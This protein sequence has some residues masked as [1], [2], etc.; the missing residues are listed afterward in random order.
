MKSVE[1]GP[2]SGKDMSP[3]IPPQ[4]LCP[5]TTIFSTLRCKTAYSMAAPTPAYF[6][7]SKGGTMLAMLRTM[8]A[9]PGWKSRTCDGQTRESEQA[10]TMNLGL[11]PLASSPYSCGFFSYFS[12]LKW[13]NPSFI[14]STAGLEGGALAPPF[15]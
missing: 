8:N 12:L 13:I 4:A 3:L 14:L 9:S 6:T 11:W 5:M 7:L 2:A 10:N 1:V 15:A